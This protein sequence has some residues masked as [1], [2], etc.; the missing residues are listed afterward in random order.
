MRR[1]RYGGACRHRTARLGK[2]QAS[3]S[4][5][6]PFVA[7]DESMLHALG[8]VSCEVSSRWSIWMITRPIAPVPVNVSFAPV[9]TRSMTH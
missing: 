9:A 4:H 6:S 1:I 5:G 7:R 2:K 3:G 8:D